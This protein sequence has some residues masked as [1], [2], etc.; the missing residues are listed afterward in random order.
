[1]S[2]AFFVHS[3]LSQ[4]IYFDSWNDLRYGGYF[5][6]QSSGRRRFG[7]SRSIQLGSGERGVGGGEENSG[8][9]RDVWIPS[10]GFFNNIF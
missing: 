5:R 2:F 1:M 3:I 7:E 10:P 8:Q 4:G 9:P 6:I